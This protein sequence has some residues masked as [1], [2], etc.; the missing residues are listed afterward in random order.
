MEKTLFNFDIDKK[1][2]Y[3]NGFYLTSH[4]TRLAKLLAHYELYK[5]IT[6]LPGHIVECGVYKG[7]S[8]TRFANFR[9]S[10]ESSYSRKII[11]FDVFGKFSRSGDSNDLNFIERFEVYF[12]SFAFISGKIPLSASVPLA[13][14]FPFGVIIEYE[15]KEISSNPLSSEV[16]T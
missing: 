14:R 16:E 7:A 2:E 8:L 4:K 11:G 6:N 13:N 1:W 15:T 10:L 5:M 9:D 3:E 12:P